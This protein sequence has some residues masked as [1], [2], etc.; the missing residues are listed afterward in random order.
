MQEE[1]NEFE[2]L[3]VWELVPRPNKVMVITLKCIYKVKLD[4]LGACAS[5]V[6]DNRVKPTSPCAFFIAMW[7]SSLSKPIRALDMTFLTLPSCCASLE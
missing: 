2:R 5:Y 3:E 6:S 4:E 7:P 1:L